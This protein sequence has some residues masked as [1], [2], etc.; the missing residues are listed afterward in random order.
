MNNIYPKR[1]VAADVK[2]A[3]ESAAEEAAEQA[4]MTILEQLR[5]THG[6]KRR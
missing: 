2:L 1:R 5:S 6:A 3:S 4:A